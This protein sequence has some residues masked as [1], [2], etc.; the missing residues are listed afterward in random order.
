VLT[1][2][3]AKLTSGAF[4]Y[5]PVT[6]GH[7]SY[8]QEYQGPVMIEKSPE[9]PGNVL[10]SYPNGT[11]EVSADTPMKVLPRPKFSG[12]LVLGTDPMRLLLSCSDRLLQAGWPQMAREQFLE[13]A[14]KGGAEHLLYAIRDCFDVS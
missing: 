12:S 8:G 2:P 13:F 3:A 5:L 1:K 9:V 7:G 11:L 14:Q 10:I 6:F 4:V